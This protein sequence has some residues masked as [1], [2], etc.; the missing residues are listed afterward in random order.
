MPRFPRHVHWLAV[1]PL[2][3]LAAGA[4]WGLG[5]RERGSDGGGGGPDRREDP[6]TGCAAMET[7]IRALLAPGNTAYSEPVKAQLLDG[8]LLNYRNLECG[9]DK[10]TALLL[11]L[12]RAGVTAPT[13]GPGSP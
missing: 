10:R 13:P 8:L 9:I 5:A 3:V 11:E 2:V 4:G 6:A 12:V 1:L 7:G